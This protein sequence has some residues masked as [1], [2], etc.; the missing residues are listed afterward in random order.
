MPSFI[1]LHTHTTAS[2]GAME[3]GELVRYAEEC[4][5][6]AVAITDHDSVGGLEEARTAVHG[7]DIEV[8]DGIEFSA[9]YE[10]E[11][12]ILGLYIDPYAAMLQGA[13]QELC[14][15]RAKRNEQMILR[16]NEL[17]MDIACDDVLAKCASGDMSN[18]GR[19]HIALALV[20]KGYALD[21]DDA[22][23]KYLVKGAAAYIARERFSPKRCIEIIKSSGGYAFLAHPVYSEKESEK[24]CELIDELVGYGLDGVECYHSAQT[25][26]FSQ[27]CVS[28]CQSRNLLIS[29]GSDFHGINRTDARIGQVSDGRY[30][31]YDILR[32]I[33]RETGK[34]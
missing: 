26:E 33:K 4:G 25:E 27:M 12:H 10:N 11:L 18:V 6:S 2:D 17:G 24:L 5:L 22:F 20:D 19:V 34:L 29:G 32:D 1:D 31:E 3:P 15:K 8:I 23:S 30:I 7:L 21:I 9:E 13:M 14:D 16:L 28:L